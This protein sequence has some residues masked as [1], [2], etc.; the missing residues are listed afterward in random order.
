[1]ARKPMRDNDKPAH[2]RREARGRG[3]VAEGSGMRSELNATPLI[4]LDAVVLDTET[5]GLDAT[6]ARVIEVA[7]IRIAAGRIERSATFRTLV[8]P[9]IPVPLAS[10]AIHGI[11]DA[12][13]A[14]APDFA[15]AWQKLS[16]FV[17][18]AIVIGHTLGFDLAV[19]KRECERA[20]IAWRQPRGLDTRLLAEVAARHLAGYS[21]EHLAA[22]LGVPIEGRHA[23]LAD[24][25]ITAEIFIALLPKLRERGVRTLAE[26]ENACRGLSEVL[27]DHHRAGWVAPVAPAPRE[28]SPFRVDTFPYRYRIR[29]FMNA[30]KFTPSSTTIADALGRMTRERISSLFVAEPAQEIVRAAVVA[31]ITEQDILSAI[32]EHGAAALAMPVERAATRPLLTVPADSYAYRAIGRMRRLKL[33]HLGV[34]DERGRLIGAVSARDLLQMRAEE[35]V[36]LGEDIEH[37]ADEGQ[38]AGAWAA[39]PLIAEFLRGDGMPAVDI[40]GIISREVSAATRRAVAIAEQRMQ[41]DGHGGPP[42]PYAVAVLGSAGRGESLL[43]MDQDNALIFAEGAPDSEA[44]KWFEALAVRFTDI[45]HEV[46]VP[47]C[48]GGVMAR[49]PQWRGST[50][51]WRDRVAGWVMRSRPED[52]LSVD[53]FFDLRGVSGEIALASELRQDAYTMASG[54]LGFAKLLAESAGATEAGLGLF[55]RFKTQNGRIDLK[56]AG[57]FG[58]VSTARVLAIRHGAIARSTPERLAGIMAL[59]IGGANDLAALVDAHG[60]FLDLILDQQIEDMHSGLPPTNAVA[61]KRLSQKNQTR[62]RSALEAVRGLDELT[63]DLLFKA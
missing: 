27:A 10:T 38:L 17:G 24:A 9:G 33:R 53:I 31:I 57:L 21:I 30:A 49:N 16:A 61:P 54:E 43:A 48:K 13:L 1:M 47:L 12:K 35:A 46:G 7:A 52:L 42:C 40:A 62:L 41:A 29:D 8:Q 55:G 26:A 19:L 51:T 22:W 44:D 45:L 23:A 28:S 6:S 56:K 39:L 14:G 60:V 59:G 11:D 20:A 50:L 25:T 37:A 4:A 58:I 63:R 5:T 34:T 15:A 32:A 2:P 3:G 18:N 36:W